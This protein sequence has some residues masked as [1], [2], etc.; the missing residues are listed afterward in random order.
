M[1]AVDE[2][3]TGIFVHNKNSQYYVKCGVLQLPQDFFLSSFFPFFIPTRITD[4][5]ATLIDNIFFN[6]IEHF[7]S[8]G[9]IVHDL[10][11]HLPTFIVFN[12]FSTLPYNVKIFKRDYSKFMV[13]GLGQIQLIDWES[14]FVSNACP[15]NM[16]K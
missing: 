15:C 2:Y 13:Q 3:T 7:T 14:V 5:S 8:S 10:T 16:L 9:N 11:D 12:K 1:L 4:H 6:S